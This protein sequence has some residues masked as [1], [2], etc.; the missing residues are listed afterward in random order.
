MG[1][2]LSLTAVFIMLFFLGMTVLRTGLYQ[3]S[4]HK[5]EYFLANFTKNTYVGILTGTIAT[6]VLQSSSLIMVLT[7]SFVSI[8]FLS[9]RQSIGIM[10]GANIG[11]TVTGELMAFSNVIPETTF[12]IIGAIMIFINNRTIF[13]LGTIL[14]GLGTIFVALDGFESLAEYVSQIPALT[15]TIQFASETPTAGVWVGL[16]VSA[17][18]QSSSAT[19]GLTMSFLHEGILPLSASIAIVLG[20]NIGTCVTS[21][22]A[23]LGTKK[24]AKLVAMSHV[25]F[26][27]VGVLLFIPFLGWLSDLAQLLATD[28]KEQL[29]HISVLFN[30]L[31]VLFLLPFINLFEKFIIKI[32]AK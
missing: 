1:N 4:Y 26:N 27:I 18:I 12:V 23:I 7:I 24:Q 16:V 6:T 21:I 17:I 32:H 30:V 15:E 2:L 31:M 8:G 14:F 10:L 29:A 19:V 13:S 5:M 9:F 25:W 28:V 22:L 20:S 11:T 3:L